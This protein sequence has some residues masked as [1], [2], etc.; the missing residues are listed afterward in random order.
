MFPLF[1]GCETL[2]FALREEHKLRTLDYRVLKRIFGS[3][4]MNVD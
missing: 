2:S 1:Y 3:K 4:K